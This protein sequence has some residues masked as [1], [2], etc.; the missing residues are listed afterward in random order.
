MS[1][2]DF[3]LPTAFG[4][5]V[6]DRP[7]P[8]HPISL[9]SPAS[10][11]IIGGGPIGLEAALYGRFLGYEVTVFEQGDM[12]ANV[13]RWG[14]LPMWTPFSMLHSRLG[15]QAITAQR[16][17]WTWPQDED[18]MTGESWCQAYLWPLAQ[19]DLVAPCLRAHH[20]VVSV[21][22]CRYR[23]HHAPTL[24]DRWQDGFELVWL[25]ADHAEQS[26][27]FDFVIDASGTFGNPQSWGPGGGL[28]IGQR[29]LQ[30]QWTSDAALQNALHDTAPDFARSTVDWPSQRTLILGETP[31]AAHAALSL[32]RRLNDASGAPGTPAATAGRLLW[33]WE[34]GW[35]TDSPFPLQPADPLPARDHQ[36]AAA[37]VLAKTHLVANLEDA[38]PVSSTSQRC[39]VVTHTVLQSIAWDP[40]AKVFR[41]RLAQWTPVD[42]DS[43]P[44][45][46]SEPDEQIVEAEFDQV[47]L[48][49]GHRV[50]PTL[51]E[52]LCIPRCPQTECLESLSQPLA[53]WTSDRIGFTL[54][55]PRWTRTPEGRYFV[56]GAKS[57]GRQPNYYHRIGLQQV[58]DTFRWII[59]RPDLDLEN[60]L[61]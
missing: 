20:R 3:D 57:F 24:I 15:R 17:D 44:D 47:I 35:A 60:S 26:D 56:L 42:W 4:E 34:H 9:E 23:L 58:R 22:R 38:L 25:D 51:T 59:G 1:H 45:D 7:H 11:A 32:N 14:H 33:A 52:N 31:V 6:P 46:Y 50:D 16:P 29:T 37:N 2:P 28:A 19:S 36:F 41:V 55:D 27:T 48:A 49:H 8:N 53:A 54:D 39:A 18:A 61:R 13:Q 30:Q 5:S 21:S 40:S 43:A 12:T 10:I